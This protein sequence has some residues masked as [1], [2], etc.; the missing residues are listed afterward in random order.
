MCGK[1]AW[2]SMQK[3]RR[4]GSPFPL[5]TWGWG[6]PE[7]HEG[8][9]WQINKKMDVSKDQSGR[10]VSLAPAAG[11]SD[12]PDITPPC[13]VHSGVWL[14]WQAN[15]PGGNRVIKSEFRAD[16][17]FHQCIIVEYD[18]W[19]SECLGPNQQLDQLNGLAAG[20]EEGSEEEQWCVD[21]GLV[22]SCAGWTYVSFVFYVVFAE[23]L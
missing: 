5:K 20:R 15:L 22:V 13:S 18:Q 3:W 21:C 11:F 14:K 2:L 19:R 7:P 17:I 10:P 23:I 12:N 6:C 1:D 8:E 4:C 16:L 9:N